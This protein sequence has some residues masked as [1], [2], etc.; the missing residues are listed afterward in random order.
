MGSVYGEVREM[1]PV[2]GTVIFVAVIVLITVL[3][4][5]FDVLDEIA[6][7]K[8]CVE[9][10]SKLKFE[11]MILGMIS[12]TVF[13]FE[14]SAGE[15]L[16]DS[17]WFEAFDLAHILI[18]FIAIAFIVQAMFLF[19][20]ATHAGRHYLLHLRA[21]TSD[22]IEGLT[23]LEESP[24][25]RRSDEFKDL[26]GTIEFKILEQLFFETYKNKGVATTFDVAKYVGFL[27]HTYI[28]E[29]GEVSKLSWLILAVLVCFNLV[30]VYAIDPTAVASTCGESEEE[31]EICPEYI[32]QYGFVLG[33]LV[34]LFV[35]G[36]YVA[37]RRYTEALVAEGLKTKSV[38]IKDPQMDP[39]NSDKE[40]DKLYAYKQF[41]LKL[42]TEEDEAEAAQRLAHST[43]SDIFKSGSYESG[44]GS[45]KSGSGK[46]SPA[47][48]SGK[49]KGSWRKLANSVRAVSELT[50]SIPEDAPEAQPVDAAETTAKAKVGWSALAHTVRAVNEFSNPSAPVE[51]TKEGG[52]KHE[53]R[54]HPPRPSYVNRK[55]SMRKLKEDREVMESKLIHNE[56]LESSKPWYERFSNYIRET[57]ETLFQRD[58]HDINP[59]IDKIFWL[60]DPRIFFK[61]IEFGFLLQC[62][63]I[64]MYLTQLLPMATDTDNHLVVLWFFL[65]TLP[66]VVGFITFRQ[67]M[68]NAVLLYTMSSLHS[69]VVDKV[70]TVV[71]LEETIC[72]EVREKILSG[73][74]GVVSEEGKVN[75]I[76]NKFREYDVDDSKSISED[77]FRMLLGKSLHV[78]LTMD[79]FGIL[80]K[81][82]DFDLS[83]E[84]TWDEVFVFV[85]PHL[86][87]AMKEELKTVDLLRQKFYDYCHANAIPEVNWIATL[88]K[89]FH[90][91]DRDNSGAIDKAEFR[92]I[93]D[94]FGIT[95]TEKG[96]TLLF[97]AIDEDAGGGVSW[98]EFLELILPDFKPNT[99]GSAQYGTR[100]STRPVSFAA[101]PAGTGPPLVSSFA[102][103]SPTSVL[104]VEESKNEGATVSV[105]PDSVNTSNPLLGS[106]GQDQ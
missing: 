80:W 53:K 43:S 75:Y 70:C 66:I 7:R 96:F 17:E 49:A 25:G 98:D 57:K 31:G 35:V 91:F 6:K 61:A 71:I 21:F 13:I 37:S 12:F 5:M 59:A 36:L 48:N 104:Q 67:I 102:I 68:T 30:R 55:E 85:F 74:P 51:V 95:M 3:E 33:I 20:Y 28:A 82:I 87:K 15:E 46:G 29:I 32:V 65:L 41:L 44:S 26:I 88:E 58:K 64:S 63:Y 99:A 47:R 78:Y 22:C 60:E 105:H 4:Y 90:E 79:R 83:G 10:L 72:D 103:D 54:S 9:I 97:A 18:L 92:L 101:R 11:L 62:F 34:N 84:V 94:Y 89:Q 93:L 45:D 73:M 27:F 23:R 40:K 56:A 77:E 42:K 2:P 106:S 50:S 52:E 24:E 38:A 1:G 81:V 76:R 100:A 8:D 39:L 86:K 69:E 16:T 14:S 19:Q